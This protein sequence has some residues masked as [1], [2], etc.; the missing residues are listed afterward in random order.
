MYEKISEILAAACG[1]RVDEISRET[2]I[3]DLVRDSLDLIELTLAL[4][5]ELSFDLPDE[6]AATFDPQKLTVGEL[7]ELH[8]KYGGGEQ[9]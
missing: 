3:G 2:R 7:T 6:L 8:E 5:E 1:I 4:E 9:H